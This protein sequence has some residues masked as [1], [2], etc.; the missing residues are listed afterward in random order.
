MVVAILSLD[1]A[2]KITLE[3]P[4]QPSLLSEPISSSKKAHVETCIN[5]NMYNKCLSHLQII[6]VLAER[7]TQEQS[8]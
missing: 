3:N 4:A 7:P 8:V 5:A 2:L 6:T 1:V